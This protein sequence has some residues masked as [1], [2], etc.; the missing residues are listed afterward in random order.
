M[1]N[2]ALHNQ[3]EFRLLRYFASASLIFF[4]LVA[5]LLGYIFRTMIVDGI[6]KGYEVQ[7]ANH[8]Q[9]LANEMWDD[10]FGPLAL[11]VV[12]KSAAQVRELSLIHI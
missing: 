8:A 9:L 12:G 2:A 4:V 11:A 10:A 7:H 6:V 5:V 3:T 1:T